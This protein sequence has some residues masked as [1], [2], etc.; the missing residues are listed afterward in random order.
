MQV[1]QAE[2]GPVVARVSAEH[3]WKLVSSDRVVL[4]E[5]WDLRAYDIPGSPYW[6]FDIVSTQQAVGEPLEIIPHRYGG[7]A[8]RGPDSFLPPAVLDVRTSEG[9]DRKTGDQ[10][11]ARWVDL[12]GPLEGDGTE[13]AGVMIADH[14]GNAGHPT[15]ARIH[16]SILPFFSY[17]PAHTT[18]QVLSLPVDRPTVF[19]YRVMVHDGHPVPTLDERIWRDFA[20]P[21]AVKV[22]MKAKR[23]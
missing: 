8:Y 9:L 5:R 4:R 2:R 13:Y 20:E 1:G 17:V 7:M 18:G 19:R 3:E 21:C 16:P 14:P 22:E 12:T 23:E 11:R 6:L 15:I 10:E